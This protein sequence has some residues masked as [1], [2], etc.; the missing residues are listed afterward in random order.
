MDSAAATIESIN[1][2]EDAASKMN[3]DVQNLA[4]EIVKLKNSDSSWKQEIEMK[5]VN[6]I[7]TK[8]EEK[9]ASIQHLS[10]PRVNTLT[11]HQSRNTDNRRKNLVIAG[12]PVSVN[13]NT[14]NVI[15]KLARQINFTTSN[16]IDNCFRVTKKSDSTESVKP[17]IILL[18]FTT[19]I[20]RDGFMKCY[21]TYIKKA[22][23]PK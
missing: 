14:V 22:I 15:K 12:V 10:E 8:I 4:T 16:F 23:N 9:L 21:Y 1:K 5:I 11:E 18:K 7:D 6:T 17:P 3:A 19:E 13:E 2:I 20:L